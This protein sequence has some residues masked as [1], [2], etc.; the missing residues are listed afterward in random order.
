HP[1]THPHT[2]TLS[3]HD[4]LPIFTIDFDDSIAQD[5]DSNADYYLKLK[6]AGL[7][8]VKTALMR[9]LDLTD[10]Q[11]EEEIR[12]MNE[13]RAIASAEDLDRKSTRLNSSHVKISYAVF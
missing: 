13:E 5:R 4:A 2:Y 6:N 9:I 11:A 8:S 12:R 1:T 7:I 3:L 10:E